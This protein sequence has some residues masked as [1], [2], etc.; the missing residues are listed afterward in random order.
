M[1]VGV[2]EG[3]ARQPSLHLSTSLGTR[4]FRQMA[5]K[6]NFCVFLSN[7]GSTASPGYLPPTPVHELVLTLDFSSKLVRSFR[8]CSTCARL[9]PTSVK[10]NI[11]WA[12][13]SK[14]DLT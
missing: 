5:G 12:N 13:T 10:V 1:G 4:G 2:S 14:V 9:L 11:F 3:W 6:P 7:F 8:R